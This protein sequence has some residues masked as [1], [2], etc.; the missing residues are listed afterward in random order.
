M[1][2]ESVISFSR[3]VNGL[4]DAPLVL[5]ADSARFCKMKISSFY[6]AVC[7]VAFS[8][9][10]HAEPEVVF[11]QN[12]DDVADGTL[13]K[14]WGV[15]TGEWKV[16]DGVLSAKQ[17]PAEN[18][19]AASRAALPMQD[20]VFKM[21]FRLLEG[22][23]S[24]HFGFDPAKG[25]LDKKGHL[26]SV[27]ISPKSWKIMKHVDKN[28][29]EEDPNEDLATA[30]AVFE[31]G[32]WYELVLTKQGDLAKASIEGIGELEATHP[33]FHVKTPALVFRSLGTGAVEVDDV[34][35]TK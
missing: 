25:E 19:S 3:G 2:F 21:K 30:D 4:K 11:E 14:G 5:F 27:I 24:F 28:K 26:F 15:N 17:I 32:K 9:A 12:F 6:P 29:R 8:L 13:P 16:V 1:F 34:V 33:T 10:A 7:L 31:T 22:A 23:T 20:G 35:V 18:H